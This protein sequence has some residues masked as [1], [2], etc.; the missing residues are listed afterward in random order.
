MTL[1]KVGGLPGTSGE[2]V[3]VSLVGFFVGKVP[4]L[5]CKCHDVI[6]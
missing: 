2:N 5:I 1:F 3:G 6:P 4:F